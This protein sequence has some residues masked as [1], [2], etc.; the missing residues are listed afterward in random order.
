MVAHPLAQRGEV[1]IDNT[2]TL[3][4]GAPF[5]IKVPPGP[6]MVSFRGNMGRSFPNQIS[7]FVRPADTVKLFF[8]PAQ[9]GG[10]QGDS[11]RRLAAEMLRRLNAGRGRGGVPR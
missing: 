7:V 10:A 9:G 6:H 3:V 4:S 2:S 5:P 8:V 11:L 1:R